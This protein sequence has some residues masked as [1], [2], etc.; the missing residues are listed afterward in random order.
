MKTVLVVASLILVAAGA[1]RAADAPAGKQICLRTIDIQ[2]TTTPDDRTILFHMNNGKV[3]RNDL[4]NSCT[5]L[6]F[7][8]FAY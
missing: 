2:N 8:G 5:G 7:N 6:K 1:A 3:W 4:R